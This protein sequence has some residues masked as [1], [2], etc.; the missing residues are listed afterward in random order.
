M[1]IQ[2]VSPKIRSYFLNHLAVL[3][4]A[5]VLVAHVAPP[6]FAAKVE[7]IDKDEADPRNEDADDA[8]KAFKEPKTGREK[9]RALFRRKPAAEGEGDSGGASGD[10]YLGLHLG[11]FLSS[12]GFKWGDRSRNDGLGNLNAGVTYRM[13]EWIGSMDLMIRA[14]FQTYT[15][16]GQ[17]PLKMSLVPMV[18]FPDV[19]SGFPLYF[20]AGIGPGIFF[21]QLSGES[22]ISLDYQLVAGARVLE[23][24]ESTGFT[25]ET[26]LKNHVHLLSD[27]QFNGFF[28]ALG[29]N[30]VF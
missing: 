9:A 4:A 17:S 26:G 5:L 7:V 18:M 10:R 29:V 12:E 20:G 1:K 24:V 30:F 28:V 22:A 14:D 19:A 25:I 27:G 15:V 16:D 2:P 23:V 21:K 8:P 13:G 3:A 11:S 6:A